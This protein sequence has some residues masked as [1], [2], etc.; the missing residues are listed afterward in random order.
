VVPT[1]IIDGTG[2]DVEGV[3]RP[4]TK[5][6]YMKDKKAHTYIITSS[7]VDLRRT[8]RRRIPQSRLM[9][10]TWYDREARL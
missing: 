8:N 6:Y 4:Q 5:D 1:I 7:F 9:C 3:I 10:R 2:Q